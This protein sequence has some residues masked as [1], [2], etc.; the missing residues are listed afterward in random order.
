MEALIAGKGEIVTDILN[1][2]KNDIFVIA[3]EGISEEKLKEFPN[4]IWLNK[5]D[6][7]KVIS[8]LK[9]RNINKVFFIGKFDQR[10]TFNKIPLNF[11]T[12]KLLFSLKDKRPEKIFEK[13]KEIL[14]KENIEVIYPKEYI[15]NALVKKEDK[16]GNFNENELENARFGMEIAKF[17]A[18]KD[19]GQTVVLKDKVVLAMEAIEGTDE[20]ILRASKLTKEDK[21]TVCKA[22]R[23][24]QSLD[25][26]IPTVGI[27]T[28]E[29]ML[30]AR[31]N[32]LVLEKNKVLIVNKEKFKEF[33]KKHKI[34]LLPL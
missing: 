31:A 30:K 16:I 28:L 11:F 27:K 1:F 4:V 23:A 26:D 10:L 33:C 13:I 9:K 20:T 34:K 12:L 14:K 21:L 6:I 24:N 3:F 8:I 25:F 5:I 18:S 32:T 22:A 29:T 2:Y 7:K 15:E 19:V 17:L